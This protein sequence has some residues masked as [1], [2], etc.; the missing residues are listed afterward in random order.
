MKLPFDLIVTV[1]IIFIIAYFRLE[2]HTF[3]RSQ[4]GDIT[5]PLLVIILLWIFVISP[6][7]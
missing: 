3:V 5:L 4:I 2:Y 7:M 1:V 6:R